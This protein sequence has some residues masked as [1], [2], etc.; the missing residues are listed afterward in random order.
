M[1]LSVMA[2]ASILVFNE[3]DTHC[4]VR[5]PAAKFVEYLDEV[6]AAERDGLVRVGLAGYPSQGAAARPLT[7]EF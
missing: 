3:D 2:L 7:P 4:L 1:I 6:K 5:Q